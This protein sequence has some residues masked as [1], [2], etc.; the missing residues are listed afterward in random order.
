MTDEQAKDF[1][2]RLRKVEDFIL[3]KLN[4]LLDLSQSLKDRVETLEE[5]DKEFMAMVHT[6]CTLKDKEIASAR[7]NAIDI[8]CKHADNNH[9]QTWSVIAF[10]VTV[11]I[12][13]IVY[14]N[15]E[16]SQRSLDIQKNDTQIEN[17]GRSLDK[18]DSK[19]DKLSEKINSNGGDR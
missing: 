10:L 3:S 5:H 4:M 8:S 14:F 18:I 6:T 1:E 15:H 19:L 12:S 17:I 2:A 13:C 11:I 9:K 16:N 7:E